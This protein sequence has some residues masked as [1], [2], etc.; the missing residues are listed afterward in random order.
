MLDDGIYDAASQL[1]CT[2]VTEHHLLQ[3]TVKMTRYPEVIFATCYQDGM[4]H[5][6]E[7]AIQVRGTGHYSHP[8]RSYNAIKTYQKLQKESRARGRYED[9]AYIEGYINGSVYLMLSEAER[10]TA[11]PSLYLVFGCKEA[12]NSIKEYCA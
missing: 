1:L 12:I 8:C 6:L 10:A 2:L 7:A 3:H 5:A 9:V 11:E 4:I